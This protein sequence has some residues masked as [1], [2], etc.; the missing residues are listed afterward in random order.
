MPTIF[1][2]VFQKYKFRI[3]IILGQ[4]IYPDDRWRHIYNGLTFSSTSLIKMIYEMNN[5]LRNFSGQR[6]KYTC[7]KNHKNNVLLCS[8]V[9][10][11]AT[12]NSRSFRVS[13]TISSNPSFRIDFESDT[14]ILVPELISIRKTVS[15]PVCPAKTVSEPVCPVETIPEQKI[16]K[17]RKL[18]IDTT[19]DDTNNAILVS[20]P[21]TPTRKMHKSQS[22]ES[23][24][25]VYDQNTKSEDIDLRVYGLYIEA[26]FIDLLLICC[27]IHINLKINIPSQGLSWTDLTLFNNEDFRDI[28]LKSTIWQPRNNFKV[29]AGSFYEYS[30]LT[31]L[32]KSKLYIYLIHY[33]ILGQKLIIKKIYSC[34]LNST[35]LEIT[36]EVDSI[37]TQIIIKEIDKC[38]TEF[39][40]L[41]H[42]YD[43]E[44]DKLNVLRDNQLKAEI[45]NI[46]MTSLIINSDGTGEIRDLNIPRFPN[47]ISIPSKLSIIHIDKE[48][49]I[50]LENFITDKFSSILLQIN[51]DN[52]SFSLKK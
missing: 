23:L 47:N 31:E 33:E 43:I 45:A 21:K 35:N 40:Q 19:I 14:I 26:L 3:F 41:C 29:H 39:Q 44:F 16:V 46:K 50:K 34:P 7:I 38:S 1:N 4:I 25:L 18:V 51:S 28:E 22:I 32:T 42:S 6:I 48:H 15:E 30:K 5:Y 8:I 37:Y 11:S 36:K 52:I 9:S 27:Q 12:D 17:K 24:S 20:T 10:P 13:N 2:I 49:I